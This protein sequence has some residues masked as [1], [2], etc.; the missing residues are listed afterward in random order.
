MWMMDV[1]L[2]DDVMSLYRM[3]IYDKKSKSVVRLVDCDTTIP[4]PETSQ[5]NRSF[6]FMIVGIAGHCKHCV[7]YMLQDKCSASVN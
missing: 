4:E 2:I 7:A 3:T 1:V 5:G 6:V